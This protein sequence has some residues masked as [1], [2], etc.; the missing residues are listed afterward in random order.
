MGEDTEEELLGEKMLW[1]EL[2]QG[3][4]SYE[5]DAK[6]IEDFCLKE[7]INPSSKRQMIKL[8]ASLINL[9]ES[10]R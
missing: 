7:D 5:E 1:D 2:P 9:R 10:L 3:E 6:R 8:T 4:G